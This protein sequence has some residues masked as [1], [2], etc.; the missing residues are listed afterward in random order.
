L[1]KQ[2]LEF[3]IITLYSS[4]IQV[5]T[6]WFCKTLGFQLLQLNTH[7]AEMK[8]G[9]GITFY[10]STNEDTDRRLDLITRHSDEIRGS[11]KANNV[12]IEEDGI[13]SFVF[14]DPD[15]NRISAWTGGFGME[16]IEI[17][18]RDVI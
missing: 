12:E 2:F 8:V 5:S 11:L 6:E 17:K 7:S 9:P 13:D 1:S 16:L 3:S 15:N 10:L 14:R 18:E 4:D